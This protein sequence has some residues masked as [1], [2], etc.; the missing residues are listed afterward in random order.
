MTWSAPA[1]LLLPN[2]AESEVFSVVSC[3][4]GAPGRVKVWFTMAEERK[5]CREAAQRT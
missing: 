1:G 5:R 4:P 3:G 2:V